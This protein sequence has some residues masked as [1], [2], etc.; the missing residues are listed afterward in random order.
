MHSEAHLHWLTPLYFELQFKH[1][2]FSYSQITLN[3]SLEYNYKESTQAGVIYYVNSQGVWEVRSLIP[4][5]FSPIS[6]VA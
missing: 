4:V 6:H 2:Y 1:Y 5:S 3:L